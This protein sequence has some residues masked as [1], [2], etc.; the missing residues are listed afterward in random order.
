MIDFKNI[1]RKKNK[2]LIKHLNKHLTMAEKEWHDFNR[3]AAKISP[4]TSGEIDKYKNAIGK[5]KNTLRKSIWKTN[6]D[7]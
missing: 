2:H 7:N 5:K 4:L 6:K 1:K 3:G